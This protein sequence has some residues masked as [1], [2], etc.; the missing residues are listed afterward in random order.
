MGA[1]KSSKPPT[2]SI[3][4][5]S[6]P[7]RRLLGNDAPLAYLF[8]SPI[9][10]ILAGLIAY[11][12][13]SAIFLSLQDKMVGAPG[14]FVGLQNYVALLRDAIFRRTAVNTFIYTVVGVTLKA[15]LGMIIALV[16]NE[17][18]RA[19]NLMRALCF[20]PWAFPTL[21]VALN[22]KWIY[23]GTQA[24]LLNMILYETG[25]VSTYVRWLS[26]IHLALFSVIA[27]MV[28][29][30]TP[31]YAMMFLAGMQ[32]IPKELYEAAE[33]DG[34][35]IFQRFF[36]ITLPSLTNVIII[37]MLLSTIWTANNVEFVYILTGGGPNYATHIFPTFSYELAIASRRL[38]L[39]A[40][41]PLMF[42]PILIVIIIVLTRRMLAEE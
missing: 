31:F 2:G 28:W 5:T 37:T 3:V 4:S 29:Q 9:F 17:E 35:S 34:A 8:L 25:L 26:D 1:G 27:A 41:V 30:G 42:L 40:T 16:I 19:R 15:I 20:L 32:A 22:W 24:G 36:K 11:P 18:I 7:R 21:I 13:F 33:V 14:T 23:E 39:G 38:G 12:F 6:L 10:L